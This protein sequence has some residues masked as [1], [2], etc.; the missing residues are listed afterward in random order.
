MYFSLQFI[1]C[2]YVAFTFERKKTTME[3]LAIGQLVLQWVF[4][5]FVWISEMWKRSF[6]F[7]R[8]RISC[9]QVYSSIERYNEYKMKRNAR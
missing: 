6:F 2:H 8:S 5:E 1:I 3:S 7:W 4:L 9:Y